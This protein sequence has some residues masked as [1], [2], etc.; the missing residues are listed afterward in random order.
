VYL[1]A[2]IHER[3]VTRAAERLGFTQPRMS[4][5]LGQLRRA[6]RDPLLIR[7][8]GGMTPTAKARVLL[9]EAE[10]ILARTSRL[11][12][13]LNDATPP[14][15]LSGTVTLAASGSYQYFFMPT[16]VAAVQREAPN[17]CL[18]AWNSYGS[19]VHEWLESGDVDIGIGPRRVS[20]GRL[21]FKLLFSDEGVCVVRSGHPILNAQLTPEAYCAAQHLKF[22][23]SRVGF[24]DTAVDE[25]LRKRRLERNVVLTVQNSLVIPH[26]V[27]STDLIA[28]V[29]RRIA[30]VMLRLAPI[31]LVRAPMALPKMEIGIF[32]HERVHRDP[33]CTYV[34]NVLISSGQDLLSGD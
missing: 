32:W 20:S 31:T 10:E 14:R 11:F 24:F 12:D 16:L 21:R 18:R 2:L 15:L 25:I 34:R 23:P 7:T 4:A 13:A 5:I 28:I 22:A 19:K 6:F 9:V 17:V 30:R 27:A 33:L 3:S 8:R 26:V 29:P 1:Q